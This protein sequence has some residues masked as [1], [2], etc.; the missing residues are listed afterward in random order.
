MNY[1]A[2]EEANARAG[3]MVKK[4]MDSLRVKE[5]KFG[6]RTEAH[7]LSYRIKHIREFLD[8]GHRV[9][10]TVTMYGREQAHPEVCEAMIT[11]VLQAIP[12]DY[13]SGP[14]KSEGRNMFVMVAP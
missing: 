2:L 6:V 13:K 4:A 12:G 10:I 5:V 9:K 1:K 8:K 3:K 14:I 7:D 11:K